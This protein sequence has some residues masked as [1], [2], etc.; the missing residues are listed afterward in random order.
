MKFMLYISKKCLLYIIT[1][2]NFQPPLPIA[3]RTSSI[4]NDFLTTVC[5]THIVSDVSSVCLNCRLYSVLMFIKYWVTLYT[6]TRAWPRIGLPWNAP[7]WGAGRELKW[8]NCTADGHSLAISI[9]VPALF[10]GTIL[11]RRLTSSKHNL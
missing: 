3:V 6:I 1:K 10:I 7:T 11:Y 2:I 5:L 4:F 8:D 9:L